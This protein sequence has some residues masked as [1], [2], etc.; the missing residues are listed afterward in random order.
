[1]GFGCTKTCENMYFKA[2]KN[3]ATYNDRLCSREGTAE[4][5]GMSPST[6]ADYELG[7]TK[8]VPVD[9]VVLMADLYHCPELKYGYCKT[10]CPIGRDMPIA[11]ETTGFEQSV[12]R[13]LREFKDADLAA[14]KSKFL[15]IASDGIVD[16]TEVKDVKDIITKL[17]AMA[18]IISETKLACEKAIKGADSGADA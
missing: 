15:D 2:R 9:K 12:I 3:A 13:F 1:M 7:I 18:L 4:L 16:G 11:T 5:L 10:E 17:D 8:V 14:V 6:L